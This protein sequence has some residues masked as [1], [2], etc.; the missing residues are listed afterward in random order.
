VAMISEP[1]FIAALISVS[2][3]RFGV[4]CNT[5]THTYMPLFVRRAP[6]ID[7]EYMLNSFVIP[8]LALR[9]R[10]TV[11]LVAAV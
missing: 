4:A 10:C 8:S 9:C 7:F 6:N 2:E 1:S 3:S 5:P 11:S